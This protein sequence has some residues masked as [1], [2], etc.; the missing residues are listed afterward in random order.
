MDCRQK[1]RRGWVAVLVLALLPAGIGCAKS[2]NGRPL[3]VAYSGIGDPNSWF[4]SFSIQMAAEA[5]ARNHAFYRKIAKFDMDDQKHQ[6]S[7]VQDVRDLIETTR[8]DVLVLAPVAVNRA[9]QAVQ[10]ANDA[11]VPVIIVNRDA[12]DPPPLN[13]VSDRYFT[14]I[15]SDFYNFGKEVCGKQLRKVFG[16]DRDIKILQLKG[17]EGGSNTIGMDK[18]CRDAARADGHMMVT[19]EDNGNYDF[20]QS[21]AAA[22]RQIASGC[23]FNAVFG[24][25]DTEGVGAVMALSEAAITNPK[26]KPGTDPGRGE[27]IV[28]SCDASKMALE[29]VKARLLYGV[30]TTSPYY[31]S[32]VFDA[33]EKHFA[34]EP[35]DAFIPV[36][37]F[38]IDV[39]NIAQYEAFGF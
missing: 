27:V 37:D 14:T 8:P 4:E 32:Q 39:G 36:T 13:F 7:Q 17:T 22:K 11:R 1:R 30:M 23:V 35:V 25:G 28:T 3:G 31:A 18:G 33:I 29:K 9:M 19:C 6:E 26:Y 34:R 38:F 12:E 20:A 2:E 5:G 21:Y 24:H 16:P 15:H 10:V